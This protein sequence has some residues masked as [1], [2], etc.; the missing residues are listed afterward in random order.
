MAF[1][2]RYNI[3]MS[4]R[5]SNTTAVYD[6]DDMK[7]KTQKCGRAESFGIAFVL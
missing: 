7:N 2:F 1:R 3:P 4:K 6:F 5:N